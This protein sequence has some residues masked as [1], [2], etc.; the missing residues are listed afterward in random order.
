M[1]VL[2][3][4]NRFLY[5][6]E[7]KLESKFIL[8]QQEGYLIKDTLCAGLTALRNTSPNEKG[9]YYNAFFNLSIGFERLLKLIFIFDYATRNSFRFPTNKEL[10]GFGHD[11]ASLY[12]AAAEIA[13][14]YPDS[15]NNPFSQDSINLAIVECLSEFAVET[16]YYNLDQ[17]T[18]R[19]SVSNPLEVWD[20]VVE[21]VFFDDIPQAQRSAIVDTSETFGASL[22]SVM[23][24]VTTGLHGNA[25]AL[26]KAFV[27]AA[28]ARAVNPHILWRMVQILDPMKTLV[29]TLS[30]GLQADTKRGQSIPY[31]VEFLQFVYLDRQTVLRKKRWP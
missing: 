23:T 28:I 10:K 5:T 12:S 31:M 20:R 2:Q 30:S 18:Q 9:R 16:R 24:A 22:E 7:V 4:F 6:H 17:L 15:A 25:I 11:V 13:R 19:T 1:C 3:G 8:L 29:R 26:R 14:A 27:I 21:R